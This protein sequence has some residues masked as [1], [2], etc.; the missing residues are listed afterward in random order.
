[1]T[2]RRNCWS[3]LTLCCIMNVETAQQ[4][5]L[6]T[7]KRIPGQNCIQIESLFAW[8][9]N[10][11]EFSKSCISFGCHCWFSFFRFVKYH[12]MMWKLSFHAIESQKQ[13]LYLWTLSLKHVY[14]PG[15]TWHLQVHPTQHG[16]N[17]IPPRHRNHSNTCG[18]PMYGGCW[19]FNWSAHKQGIVYKGQGCSKISPVWWYIPPL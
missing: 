17:S 14:Y 12:S 10:V 19:N 7:S 9:T 18:L 15:K 1:M 2:A 13:T 16:S 8:S 4:T 3:N 5:S 6:S 11:V